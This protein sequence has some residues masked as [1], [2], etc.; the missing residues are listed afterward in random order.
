MK[1]VVEIPPSELLKEYW[2]FENVFSEE[3]IN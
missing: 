1:A 3:E 2:K